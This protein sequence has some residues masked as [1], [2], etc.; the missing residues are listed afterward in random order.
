MKLFLIED[1]AAIRAELTRLLQK[2]GYTCLCGEGERDLAGQALSSGADLILL[3]INLPYQDGFQLC[4]EI[5]RS[6]NVPIIIITSR[7]SDFDELL[8]L[9]LGADDFISKPYHPQVLLA[10]I[11]KLLERTYEAQPSAALVHKGL[12]LYPLRG[13]IR[14]DG[15]EAVLSKNE[16][17]ILRM[18]MVNR[19]NIIPRDALIDELWQSEQFIDENTLNVNIARLRKKLAEIGLPD[20]LETR[21]GLGYC[22]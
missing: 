20:Y 4:R 11:R 8:G 13:V 7:T 9:Q 14:H 12:T 6:S 1:E 2:Y 3:D 16:L 21:R 10:R 15:Q 18:L 19:G 5:R 17:G 22:V